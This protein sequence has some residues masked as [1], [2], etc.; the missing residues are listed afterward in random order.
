M[1][2]PNSSGSSGLGG[3]GGMGVS[4]GAAAIDN[5]RAID[6]NPLPAD[7]EEDDTSDVNADGSSTGSH[8][9]GYGGR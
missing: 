6:T 1:T 7:E 8:P 9:S 4:P 5:E 2:G 3:L